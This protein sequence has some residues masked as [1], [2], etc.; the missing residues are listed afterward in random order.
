MKKYKAYKDSGIEW[1]G[2]IPEHW[3]LKPLK[4]I[5]ECNSESLP[6]NTPK[7]QLINY[8]EIGD[9]SAG[10]GITGFEKYEFEKAPSRARRIVREGDVIIS[11]VRTYLKAIASIERQFDNYVVSTG[12]AV[13][14]P[15][16]FD[17]TYLN[18]IVLSNGFIGEII[19][20]SKGVSYP[21]ITSSDLLQIKV[22][23]PSTLEQ[24]DIGAYLDQKT[25][26]ID[27]L[28]TKKEQLIKLLEEERTAMINQAVT[29]GLD[30]NVPMKDSG[31]DWLGEIPEHWVLVKLKYLT[32]IRYG[33]G[34][35]P[36]QKEGGLPIIRATNVYRGTISEENMIYVDPD[37]LP[38]NREPILKENDII[39]VRSGA[40]TADS[41]IIEKKWEGTVTGYDLV[42]TPKTVN[43]KLLSFA[44][45]STYMLDN[46][47]F[48]QRL[49]AA[50]PHLNSEELGNTFML[51]PP[52]FEQIDLVDFIE[53]E[54]LRLNEIK[55]K[56]KKEIH[57]LKEYKT[58]LISEVVTGKIDVR[59]EVLN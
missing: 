54:L 28:I 41:A 39:V 27:T 5:V 52:D 49:R 44:L 15:K 53:N 1:I 47:L 21:S 55:E 9:V 59:E 23:F 4:H 33:L 50:Q 30:P 29:K 14:T 18:N 46:Q 45:L 48:L 7:N 37:D 58:A 32:R 43:P 56:V 34:Q 3:N 8:I 57:F 12:F 2:V 20:L 25:T 36:K 16:Q 26:E 22:P 13:L 11:T 19:S 35:P 51:L 40:Y 24:E 10:Q 42:M 17:S 38:L 6:E 31:I